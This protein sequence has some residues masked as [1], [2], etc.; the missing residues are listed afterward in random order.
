VVGLNFSLTIETGSN[1]L[2][3]CDGSLVG[4]S[5]SQSFLIFFLWLHH[6]VNFMYDNLSGS[7]SNKKS[8]DKLYKD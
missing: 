8:Y 6:S 4:L 2:I 5:K 1:S 7:F 3:Q